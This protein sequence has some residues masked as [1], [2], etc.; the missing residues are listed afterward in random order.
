RQLLDTAV[1]LEDLV[2]DPGEGAADAIG[3]HHDR[4]GR[5]SIWRSGELVNWRTGELVSRGGNRRNGIGTSSQPL[6]AALKRTAP[7]IHQGISEA[8]AIDIAHELHDAVEIR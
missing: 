7:I 3:V 2:R 1:A 8:S 4:H 6:W 5:T